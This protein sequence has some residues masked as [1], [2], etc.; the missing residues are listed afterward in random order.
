MTWSEGDVK[1][2]WF[3][4]DFNTCLQ[5]PKSWKLSKSK[6]NKNEKKMQ[7]LRPDLILHGAFL[8]FSGGHTN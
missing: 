2:N 3:T 1:S 7:H 4:I 5:D 6:L 8:V